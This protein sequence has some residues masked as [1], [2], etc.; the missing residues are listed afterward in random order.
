MSTNKKKFFFNELSKINENSVKK[1]KVCSTWIETVPSLSSPSSVRWTLHSRLLQ[2]KNTGLPFSPAPCQ[3]TFF[4]EGAG[5]QCFSSCPLMPDAEVQPQVN[6]TKRWGSLF[7]SKPYSWNWGSAL[8][9][10]GWKY[11]EPK[12]P[13][14]THEVIAPHQ[15]KQTK[16]LQDAKPHLLS[17]QLLEQWCHSERSLPLPQPNLQTSI[18]LTQRFCLWGEADCLKKKKNRMKFWLDSEEMCR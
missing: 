6:T 10:A 3:R 1:M 2:V 11:R 14:P 15:V 4:P 7:L 5:L 9:M 8:G 18:A 17:T 12:S 13:F 16:R